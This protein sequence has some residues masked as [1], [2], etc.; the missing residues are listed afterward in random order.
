MKGYIFLVVF[1]FG[2]QSAF[3]QVTEDQWVTQEQIDKC[4]KFNGFSLIIIIMQTEGNSLNIC[5]SVLD[6]AIEKG[7]TIK[8]DILGPAWLGEGCSSSCAYTK[9]IILERNE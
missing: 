2:V 4:T 8:T 5:S 1:I 3:A 6:K 7:Y 9:Y